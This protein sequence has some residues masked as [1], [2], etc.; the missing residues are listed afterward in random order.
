M[1]FTL[2]YQIIINQIMEYGEPCGIEV[3]SDEIL[4]KILLELA[5][6]DILNVSR[7]NKRFH[8]LSQDASLH[9]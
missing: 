7:V 8:Q 2:L 9:K 5:H 1:V 4:L 6:E 3:V